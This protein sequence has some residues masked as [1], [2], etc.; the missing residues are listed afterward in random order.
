MNATETLADIDNVLAAPSHFDGGVPALVELVNRFYTCIF[1]YAPP[2]SIYREQATRYSALNVLRGL[3]ES[4]VFPHQALKGVLTALR[5]AIAN[6]QL[7][8]FEEIVRGSVYSDLL[9]Q[10]DYLAS[11]EYFRAAAEV[12]GAAFED[13]IRQQATKRGIALVVDRKHKEMSTLLS[14]LKKSGLFV[15]AVRTTAEGW[16]KTRNDA[17]HGKPGF[18]GADKSQTSLVSLMLNGIRD[19]ILEYPV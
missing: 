4:K 5:D 2:N 14:E 6:G 17:A 12:G 19:F 3:N 7:A 1:R 16:T 10:G 18:D 13:H 9:A 8:T 11:Q 15:E